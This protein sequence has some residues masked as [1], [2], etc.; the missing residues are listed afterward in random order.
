MKVK[1]HEFQHPTLLKLNWF[2]LTAT[3]VDWKISL[4]SEIL[5]QSFF[6]WSSIPGCTVFIVMSNAETVMD[7]IINDEH[8]VSQIL[9][10]IE[11]NQHKH[12]ANF[13][14]SNWNKYS[15]QFTES[16]AKAVINRL[17]HFWINQVILSTW[18]CVLSLL[19]DSL[20]LLTVIAARSISSV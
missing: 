14:H 16:L 18:H 7:V 4:K 8:C 17:D 12:N 19:Q 13:D 6:Y 20:L 5:V 2:Y 3:E 9:L 11:L 15:L 10:F 1:L